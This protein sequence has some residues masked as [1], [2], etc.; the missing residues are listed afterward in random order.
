M[1]NILILAICI[2]ILIILFIIIIL[3]ISKKKI[4]EVITPLD[5]SKEEINDYL[6]QK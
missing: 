6:K 3:I 1:N 4:Q 5:I 2:L